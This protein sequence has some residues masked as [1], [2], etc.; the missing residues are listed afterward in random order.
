MPGSID[1]NPIPQRPRLR[2]HRSHRRT[3]GRDVRAAATH[4]LQLLREQPAAVLAPITSTHHGL[5]VGEH[6]IIEALTAAGIEA[7][8]DTAHQGGLP[9]VRVPQRRR[10]LDPDT[11]SYRRLSHSQREV[12]AARARV[13]G[14]GERADAESKNWK[15]L[16]EIRSSPSR[17]TTLVNEVQTLMI[18][19][20]T[21]LCDT[22][23]SESSG[24]RRRRFG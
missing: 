8:A 16:R 11:G 13:R 5:N 1:N 15:I 14:P 18:I 10:R 21:R 22:R 2:R 12:N 3:A 4:G 6:G 24:V 20:W 19:D 17:A 9:A 7:F 23:S